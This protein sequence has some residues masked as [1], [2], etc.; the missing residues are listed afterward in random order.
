MSS[1]LYQILD[2]F[3]GRRSKEVQEE[4]TGW[5]RTYNNQCRHTLA[6]GIF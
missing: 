5:L 1:R 3:M 6:M 4:V 2:Y